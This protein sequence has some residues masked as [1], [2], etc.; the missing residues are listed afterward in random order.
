MVRYTLLIKHLRT[1]PLIFLITNIAASAWNRPRRGHI[2][3]M[4][5]CQMRRPEKQ[6]PPHPSDIGA[7]LSSALPRTETGTPIRSHGSRHRDKVKTSSIR[8]VRIKEARSQRPTPP[9]SSDI[10]ASLSSPLPRTETGTTNRLY[11]LCHREYEKTFP[12]RRERVKEAIPYRLIIAGSRTSECELDP[13]IPARK[14]ATRPIKTYRGSQAGKNSRK[15]PR[16]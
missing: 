13:V 1:I 15:P 2:W 12:T 14:R 6:Y 9:H 7:C 11:G 5:T 4:K 10:S 8:R 16:S 3:H